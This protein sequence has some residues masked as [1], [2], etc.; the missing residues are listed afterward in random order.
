MELCQNEPRKAES[1][2]EARALCFC[3]TMDAEALCSSTVK[4]AK[5][6]CIGT[7]KETKATHACTIWEAET[8]CCA[9]IRD[10]ETS[11]AESLYRQHAKSIQYLE[12]QVIRE[13]GRSQTDF[14]SDCHAALHASP[15]ELKG[16]L[17]TS[18]H[19]LMGQE[20]TSHP[21]TLSQ[22]AYPAEQLSPQQLLMP[23]HLRS[24]PGPKGDIL[25][26]TPWTTCLLV[27]LH[28]RPP[29][30]GPLAPNG[31]RSHLGT[32]YSSRAAQKHSARTLI[33]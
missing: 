32:R 27:E 3:V 8:V 10:A 19:I 31:E 2:K 13:E 16:M 29:W 6:T 23:Q 30:K 28:P 7:I 22:G 26:Q 25:P 5:V 17:V 24:P 18:Y 15:A 12:E 1:I 9:A 11:Q 21:F 14:L 33:W 4:E 20:P